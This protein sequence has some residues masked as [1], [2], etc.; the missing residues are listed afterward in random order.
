MKERMSFE[1]IKSITR[2]YKKHLFQK[3]DILDKMEKFRKKTNITSLTQEM[4]N[5]KSL[6]EKQS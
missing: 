3:L 6:S 5:V 4:K 1:I 2:D